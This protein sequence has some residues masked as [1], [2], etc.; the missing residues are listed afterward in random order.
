MSV[1]K[2][3]IDRTMIS[4]PDT[5]PGI[6]KFSQLLVAVLAIAYHAFHLGK[7]KESQSKRLVDWVFL[8]GSNRA[9]D[10]IQMCLILPSTLKNCLR[11]VKSRLE[12]MKFDGR[13]KP[14]D[15][16]EGNT[17]GA[18]LRETRL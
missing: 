17:S 10:G 6:T 18:V 13:C 7:L 9:A 4:L 16:V 3:R 15:E 12:P 14:C 5:I 1:G 8:K 2:H 11:E